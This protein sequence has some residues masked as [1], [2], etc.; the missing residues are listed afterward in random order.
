MHSNN[1]TP[2]V[3]CFKQKSNRLPLYKQLLHNF[4]ALPIIL[5]PS[6][7]CHQGRRNFWETHHIAAWYQW[8]R[9]S[10]TIIQTR[11][12]HGKPRHFYSS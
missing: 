2:F 4:L 8:F 9:W 3:S 10:F 5:L 11:H 1:L 7:S 6:K 12:E